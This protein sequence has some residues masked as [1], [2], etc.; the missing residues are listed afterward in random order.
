MNPELLRELLERLDIIAAKLDIAAGA[1]WEILI[2]QVYIR[3]IINALWGI[4][5]WIGAGAMVLAVRR[6]EKIIDTEYKNRMSSHYYERTLTLDD[7]V[8]LQWICRVSVVV[9]VILGFACITY[10]ANELANPGYFA[11]YNLIR[12]MK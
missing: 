5:I 9:L 4:V 7:L 6:L 10:A 8:A 2:R 12:E 1:V 3:G 11:I